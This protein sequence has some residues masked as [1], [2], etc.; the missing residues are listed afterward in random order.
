MKLNVFKSTCK[1]KYSVEAPKGVTLKGQGIT[2]SKYCG[3][4]NC[5]WVTKKAMER[6]GNK[7]TI[8]NV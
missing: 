4:L 1:G 7:Y 6:L 5:Y 3:E 2:R 8:I